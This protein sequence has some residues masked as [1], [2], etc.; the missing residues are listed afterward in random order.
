[1]SS[2]IY[3]TIVDITKENRLKNTKNKNTE[4]HKLT[5]MSSLQK[6]LSQTKK[7]GSGENNRSKK[8]TKTF[9]PDIRTVDSSNDDDSATSYSS[10][11]D[12]S[13]VE[14]NGQQRQ[15][16]ES[17]DMIKIR[18]QAVD[19][20]NTPSTGPNA[21]KFTSP[22]QQQS[23]GELSK[24]QNPYFSSS[25]SSPTPNSYQSSNPYAMHDPHAHPRAHV[26]EELSMKELFVNCVS[27]VCKSSSSELLH[28]VLSGGYKSVSNYDDPPINGSW[29]ES[30][31][32]SQH[33]YGNGNKSY[34]QGTEKLPSRYQ[35]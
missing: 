8:T 6:A 7:G 35:D 19:L 12:D 17:E 10:S 24:G 28:K 3:E 20:I 23:A 30:L 11:D 32:T 21:A 29:G 25:A 22:Y 18:Q 13:V 26:A 4:V 2:R 34:E 31:D 5:T 16:R 14:S 33:G 9:T 27:D 1:M 15:E